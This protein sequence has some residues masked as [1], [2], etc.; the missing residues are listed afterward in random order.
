MLGGSALGVM[1]APSAPLVLVTV[2]PA[3]DAGPLLSQEANPETAGD[4]V[5]DDL[6]EAPSDAGSVV[7]AD[8]SIVDVPVVAAAPAPPRRRDPSVITS[9][10]VPEGPVQGY[11]DGR[12]MRIV[13][14]RLDA[15]PVEVRT[16]A[17]YLRMRDAALRDNVR[18]RIVSGFRTMAH[19][20]AL[21]RAYRRGRGNLAAVPGHSNH[22]SGHALDLN[23][24]SPGVLRWLDR[25]A[26]R[27]GFRRTVPTES[28]H[29]EW[30]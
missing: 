20:Q 21:Y 18:L 10:D 19:Q 22:Q 24:S 8:E 2:V 13:V 1:H 16:A 30:W 9:D 3:A 4:G 12:S 27:F 17:A 6:D 5:M 29:W 11:V 26:R 25:N 15:K 7:I 14:R 28:W 23:T